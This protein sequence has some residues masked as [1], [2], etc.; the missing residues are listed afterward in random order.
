MTDKDVIDSATMNEIIRLKAKNI[1]ILGGTGAISANVE[2]SLKNSSYTVER[3]YDLDRY[4]TAV[5]IGK[6]IST[7]TVIITTGNDYPDALA[8]GPFAA[9]KGYPILFT[10]KDSLNSDTKQALTDWKI[11]NAIIVGGVGVV[12]KT[13]ED[14]MNS[15]QIKVTRLSGDNRYLTALKIVSNFNDGSF[16]GVL[17]ATGSDFPDALAGGPLATKKDYPI[18]LVDKDSVELEVKIYILGLNLASETHA[19]GGPSVVSDDVIFIIS[20]NN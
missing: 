3:I 11:K 7:D 13:V 1:Y 10:T 15:M 12:S 18:F 20:N 4:K 5:K 17:V 16:K 6:F 2:N 9:K 14:E 19:L 8:I